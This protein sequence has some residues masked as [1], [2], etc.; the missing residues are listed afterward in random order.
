MVKFFIVNNIPIN[1]KDQDRYN[2]LW[3]NEWHDLHKIGPSVRTRNRILIKFFRKYVHQGKILDAGCGDG[4]LLIEL[5]KIYQNDL[6]YEAGDISNNALQILESFDFISSHYLI[7]LEQKSTL[8]S[9]KYIAVISSEVLEH[10]KDWKKAV[11]NIASLVE[12]NGFVFITVPA[13]MKYWGQ[14]DEFALHYRRFE[15]NEIEDYL[16]SQGF[17]VKES[18]CWGWPFYW[19]YYSFFLNKTPP[20]LVMKEITSPIKKVISKI[21]FSLFF[22]DDFFSTKWGRRLFI[23]AQK[24]I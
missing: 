11:N 23:V 7:D 13:Q 24:S 1:R 2:D 4:S 16:R 20:Q 6:D 8:P 22:I 15:I 18:I 3:K 19:I 21:L 5:H 17:Q 12:Q 10:I 14:H 9:Q